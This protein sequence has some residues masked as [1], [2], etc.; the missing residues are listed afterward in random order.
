MNVLKEEGQEENYNINS[1][2]LV[3]GNFQEG[4]VQRKRQPFV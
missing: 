1:G 4:K 3:S 2:Q